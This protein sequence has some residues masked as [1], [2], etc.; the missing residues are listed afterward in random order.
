MGTSGRK[1]GWLVR[2][3]CRW[4]HPGRTWQV[5]HNLL[6]ASQ[7]RVVCRCCGTVHVVSH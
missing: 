5:E 3:L 1:S 6:R 7:Y 2:I 4:R